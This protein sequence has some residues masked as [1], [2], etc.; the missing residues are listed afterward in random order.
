MITIEDFLTPNLLK[1]LEERKV[2][3]ELNPMA[4]LGW[5]NYAWPA[6]LKHNS[7]L[8]WCSPCSEIENDVYNILLD[9]DK[10]FQQCTVECN[11][12]IWGPLSMLPFHN[13]T[14]HAFAVT[15]YL[16]HSWNVEDGGLFIYKN[17]EE[18]NKLEVI[19]PKYNLAVLN[20]SKLLHHV[21]PV[22]PYAKE[23]R[24]TLQVWGKYK[25][26]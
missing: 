3:A 25:S 15:V 11:F 21:T 12:N 1:L 2:L 17:E 20:N 22:S 16:N 19:V 13:D 10:K 23:K 9:I 14:G 7:G 6:N 18:N 26:E 24:F 5:S 4:N 8:I